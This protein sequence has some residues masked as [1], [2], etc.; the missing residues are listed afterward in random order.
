M[1][2]NQKLQVLNYLEKNKTITS[3]ESFF[4]LD[5]TDLQHAIMLLR[6]EG[7]VISD[8][9]I[10]SPNTRKRYKEYRLEVD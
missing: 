8:K 10:T 2:L 7:Y 9:W 3:R 5:I 4:K 1:Y 6:K